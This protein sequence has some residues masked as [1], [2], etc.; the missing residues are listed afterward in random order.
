MSLTYCCVHS[1]SSTITIPVTDA[2]P[3]DPGGDSGAE[4]K[5]K[6]GGKKFVVLFVEFFPAL[7]D[8]VSGPTTCSVPGSPRMRNTVRGDKSGSNNSK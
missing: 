6:K 7:F 8:F 5:V 3:Q 1:Y 4:D 2:H